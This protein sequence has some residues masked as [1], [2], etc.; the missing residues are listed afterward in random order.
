ML[1]GGLSA[2]PVYKLSVENRPYVMKLDAPRAGTEADPFEKVALAAH[3]GIAPALRYRNM[4]LGVIINDFVENKPIRSIF[5]AEVLAGKLAEAVRKIHAISY[6][7]PGDDLKATIDHMLA[8]FRQ[9]NIL[10]GEIPD[11]CLRRYEQVKAAYPWHDTDKVFSHNDLNPSNILCDGQEIR[12]VDWDTASVNDRYIDL[13]GV[14]NFFIHMPGQ[15]AIF[16]ETYFGDELDAYKTARFYVMRQVSRIIYAVLMLQL[17]SKAK[18]ADYAHDQDVAGVFLKDVGPAIGSGKLSL[19]TYEGQF[20]YGKALMHEAVQQ[21]RTP[22]FEA[23]LAL[24]KG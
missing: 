5:T 1:A 15:E 14:A 12:I 8:G 20:M 23:S 7:V 19:A 13:A 22:R 24:L 10:S 2:A 21:M 6:P 18:P 11:E 3:A 17:A 9:T 4:E 16:L